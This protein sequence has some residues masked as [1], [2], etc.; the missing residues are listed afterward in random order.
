MLLDTNALQQVV[1][2]RH[3]A[4]EFLHPAH[5]KNTV[6]CSVPY[7]MLST[8]IEIAQAYEPYVLYDALATCNWQQ[9]NNL[10]SFPQKPYSLSRLKIA[11]DPGHFAHN[12]ST[13][14]L[15][16]KYLRIRDSIGHEYTLYE[17]ALTEQI[18]VIL[19]DMLQREGAEVMLTRQPGL[20]T[21]GITAEEWVQGNWKQALDESVRKGWLEKAESEKYGSYT[22]E[23]K[24]IRDVFRTY[25]MHKRAEKINSFAPHLVVSIHL[26]VD[27]KNVPDKDGF[28]TLH[29]RNYSM[30][31]VP[32][33]YATEE[34]K[35]PLDRLAFLRQWLGQQVPL[36]VRAAIVFQRFITDS[37]VVP[38]VASPITNELTYLLK[39][40]RLH[41]Q[42]NPGVY[43]RNLF[44]LRQVRYPVILVEPFL[45][46][47]EQEFFQ[48]LQK[49]SYYITI[50]GDTL[51]TSR[52]I[53]QT[54]RTYFHA[55]QAWIK[56]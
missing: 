16:K 40:S 4:V 8:L 14:I 56:E 9:L 52:R 12:L 34:L 32:G 11:I 54:A 2:L 18:A 51:N 21:L 41:N 31:F 30:V 33:A 35:F 36:S 42:S 6:L 29:K 43:H 13:A 46:D 17:A 48:L 55:I 27:E 50:S 15:E 22:D 26:N 38:A 1:A 49:D 28:H 23:R 20:S 10:S 39:F 44:L 3:N 45:Q 24:I 25:E 47:N 7:Q 53:L 37:L 19:Q 5:G